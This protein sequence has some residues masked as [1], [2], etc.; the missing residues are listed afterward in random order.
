MRTIRWLK[1]HWKNCKNP[2]PPRGGFDYE[3][4]TTNYKILL[5]VTI[6]IFNFILK[7]GIMIFCP[8]CGK[9]IP[10]DSKFCTFCGVLIPAVEFDETVETNKVVSA[11]ETHTVQGERQVEDGKPLYT[12]ANFFSS[13]GFWGSILV[14]A[15]FFLP[16]LIR[17]TS[18]MSG[19]QLASMDYEPWK[20]V[21]L[22]FPLSAFILLIQSLTGSL[23][24]G[25]SGFFKFIPFLLLLAFFAIMVFGVSDESDIK[26]YGLDSHDLSILIKM[27]GIGIWATTIGSLLMLFHKKYTRIA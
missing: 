8:T 25:L 11:V 6:L 17:D 10:V 4:R 15:G 21:L 24:A 18:R 27:I 2:L 7:P 13:P 20:L 12:T 14:L 22:L 3:L 16:W 9:A 5:P 26:K 1:E 23:P 19:L